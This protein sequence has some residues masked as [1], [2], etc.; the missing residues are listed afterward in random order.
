[1][2]INKIA[3]FI[4][5]SASLADEAVKLVK[6]Q[7]KHFRHMDFEYAKAMGANRFDWCIY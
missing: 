5:S 3:K 4:M 6:E 1:M 7:V 2:N